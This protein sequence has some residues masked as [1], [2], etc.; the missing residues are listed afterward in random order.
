MTEKH[1]PFA[2]RWDRFTLEELQSLLEFFKGPNYTELAAE[3]K[4]AIA[5]REITTV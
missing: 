4:S 2:D 3:I 5:K 1:D